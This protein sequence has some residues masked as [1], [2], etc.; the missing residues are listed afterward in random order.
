LLKTKNSS[1]ND[2]PTIPVHIRIL[3][4]GANNGVNWY[5]VLLAS[6]LGLVLAQLDGEDEVVLLTR[7]LVVV[8]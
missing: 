1:Q 3:P 5:G 6:S 2:S 4:L 7:Q 8:D